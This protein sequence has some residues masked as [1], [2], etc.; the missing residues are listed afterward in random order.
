MAAVSVEI[1]AALV[2]GLLSGAVVLLGVLL[3]EGLRRRGG[4]YEE[5]RRATLTV[6]MRLPVAM[7][8]LTDTPPDSQRLTVGSPGWIIYQEVLTALVEVDA[9]SRPRRTKNRARIREANEDISARLFAA[10][11]RFVTSGHRQ[12]VTHEEILSMTGR[13]GDLNGAVF[14]K[15]KPVD[16]LLLRY[17]QDGLP[18]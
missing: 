10:N 4:R 1:T 8:Y 3:A 7:V 16:E 11:F 17:E 6:G 14:G 2:G 13:V 9:A 18:T 15:R 12:V 5:L